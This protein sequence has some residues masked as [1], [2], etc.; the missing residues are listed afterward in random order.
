MDWESS[1]ARGSER[2]RARQA[3]MESCRKLTLTSTLFFWWGFML[4]SMSDLGL[5]SPIEG[6]AQHREAAWPK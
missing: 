3:A 6:S 4:G 5:T 2:E 1:P